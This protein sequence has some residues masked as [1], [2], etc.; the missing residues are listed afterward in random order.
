MKELK[1]KLIAMLVAGAFGVG[2]SAMSLATEQSPSSSGGPA[3]QAA[4]EKDKTEVVPGKIE[5]PGVSPDIRKMD[6]NVQRQ[7]DRDSGVKSQS[8]DA[9]AAG[10]EGEKAQAAHPAESQQKSDA[11]Q[12]PDLKE[13]G[14]ER[15]KVQVQGT[16][17]ESSAEKDAQKS[18]AEQQTQ[19]SQKGT[20]QAAG[21]SG[22]LPQGRTTYFGG[23]GEQAGG[24][25]GEG[26]AGR[27]GESQDAGGTTVTRP[28]QKDQPT[29]QQ[30]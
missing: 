22:D 16:E 5:N 14:D 30:K 27:A 26:A 25:S 29:Q 12:S 7:H 8:G 13:L 28:P 17:K 9:G 10:R 2:L 1:P 19:E 23:P 11:K 21:A 20:G 15:Q 3:G 6:D 18:R 4:A 24:A